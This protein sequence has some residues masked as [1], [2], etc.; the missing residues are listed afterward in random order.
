MIIHCQTVTIQV[1]KQALLSLLHAITLFCTLLAPAPLK[2]PIV[3]C[4]NNMLPEYDIANKTN[5]FSK[6]CDM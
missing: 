1:D 6:S 3:I 5:L 4:F 2:C